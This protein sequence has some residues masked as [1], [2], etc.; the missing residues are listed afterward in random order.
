MFFLPSTLR[1]LSAGIPNNT[2]AGDMNKCSDLRLLYVPVP[3]VEVGKTLG[4]LLVE[5]RLAA[6]VNIL[7]G[8]VSVFRWQ[9]K[10]CEAREAVL[11]IKTLEACEKKIFHLLQTHHPSTCPVILPLQLGPQLPETVAQWIRESVQEKN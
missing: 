6:C 4:R 1:Q 11:L 10:L 8:V 3:D 5:H 9:E 7:P 2:G